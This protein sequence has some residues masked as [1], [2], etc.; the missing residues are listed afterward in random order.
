MCRDQLLMPRQVSTTASSSPRLIGV[1]SLI[2]TLMHLDQSNAE[3]E[4]LTH[5]EKRVFH[6]DDTYY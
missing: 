5:R 2:S 4:I 1:I 6:F 3:P